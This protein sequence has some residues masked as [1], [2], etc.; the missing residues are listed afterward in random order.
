VPTLAPRL[1]SLRRRHP[2][3]GPSTAGGS[4][5]GNAG[6]SAGGDR[7]WVQLPSAPEETEAAA[8]AAAAAAG[9]VASRGEL[10]AH[11]SLV[12]MCMATGGGAWD[13]PTTGMGGTAGAFGAA[14]D[15]GAV[16][17]GAAEGL[18]TAGVVADGVAAEGTC[19]T[20]RVAPPF[21]FIK[22]GA[23]VFMAP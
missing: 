5:S 2:A 3:T 22:A 1:F 14:A 23:V 12:D 18:A 7:A 4:A 9:L 6:G 17:G 19:S 8:D 13:A 11:G 16:L 15:G 21:S 10:G 20:R